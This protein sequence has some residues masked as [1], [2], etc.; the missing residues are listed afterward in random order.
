MMYAHAMMPLLFFLS[1]LHHLGFGLVRHVY[2]VSI[3]SVL[4]PGSGE[5]IICTAF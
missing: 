3:D 5:D 2:H 4:L 1:R